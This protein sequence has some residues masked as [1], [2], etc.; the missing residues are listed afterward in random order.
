M[1]VEILALCDGANADGGKLSLL[2]AFDTIWVQKVPITYPYCAIALR[3]R[4]DN[5]EKGEHKVTVNFVNEDG[6]HIIPALNGAI[7]LDFLL[8][9]KSASANV[10]LNLQGIKF[11]ACGEYAIDLAI[12]GRSEMSL[13][14]FVKERPPI[15]PQGV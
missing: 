7:K 8:E 6:K 13:P 15:V 2:G 3:I 12:D 4:F 10:I 14:L 9:Q 5:I 11:E 1:R